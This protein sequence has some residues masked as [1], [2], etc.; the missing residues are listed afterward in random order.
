MYTRTGKWRRKLKGGL[1]LAGLGAAVTLASTA[2]AQPPYG[3][4]GQ[5]F[6][7]SRPFPGQGSYEVG[8][9]SFTPGGTQP[10]SAASQASPAIPSKANVYYTN[11][12][13]FNLPVVKLPPEQ[14]SK[15]QSLR[16]YVRTPHS[17]WDMCESVLP[18]VDHFV[19][20]AKQDDQYW[21]VVATVDL[22]GRLSP[23]FESEV[24]SPMM[25]VVVDTRP[26]MIECQ[27]IKTREGVCLLQCAMNDDNPNPASIRVLCRDSGGIEKEMSP[28]ESP[29]GMNDPVVFRITPQDGVP[30]RVSGKDLCG[31]SVVLDLNL[32]E[33]FSAAEVSQGSGR[34]DLPP[35]NNLGTK[36]E[37]VINAN[38]EFPPVDPKNPSVLP[39]GDGSQ[40]FPSTI[41]YPPQVN[42]ASDPAINNS[43]TPASRTLLPNTSA[44]LEY[45]IEQQGQSGVGKV[46]IYVTSDQGQSWRLLKEDVHRRS[47]VDVKLPGEGVF[48][49]SVVVTNGNGFGGTPPRSGE[50]PSCWIEVDST[51][52]FVQ[53][54]PIEL[55]SEGAGLEIRWTASDKNLASEPINLYY[56]TGRAGPWLPIAAGL[57]NDGHYR[58]AFPKSGISQF[59]FKIEAVD[60]V[61]NMAHAETPE[62]T[63]VDMTEPRGVVIRVSPGPRMG[64]PSG[65]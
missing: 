55:L 14:R 33:V 25:K 47:P 12:R 21:F 51:P 4:S 63:V 35:V 38:N 15:L 36:N 13:H 29:A 42:V 45:R 34:P 48:G 9:Q 27:P 17:D 18:T 31:N 43:V 50:A 59:F 2:G 61:G 5:S 58:W 64:S 39:A 24:V 26:P 8:Q 16:L 65:N 7:G 44:S 19:F 52:P 23:R 3:S 6:N 10:N 54:R 37:S 11:K 30:V 46:Q 56:R 60:Q 32:R 40:R 57:K 53:F 20:R 1:I 28:I 22:Q 62:A 41:A 49:L